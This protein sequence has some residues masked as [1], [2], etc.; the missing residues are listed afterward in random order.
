MNQKILKE[1]DIYTVAHA[2]WNQYENVN[3][4]AFSFTVRKYITAYEV[5][6]TIDH[7]LNMCNT[8]NGFMPHLLDFAYRIGVIVTFSCVE[9]PVDYEERHFVLYNTDL[10]DTICKHINADQLNEIKYGVERCI[11]LF[12]S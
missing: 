6:S 2:N 11:C 8:E 12:T 3:W 1:K 10:F 7:I 4:H 9:L 5:E